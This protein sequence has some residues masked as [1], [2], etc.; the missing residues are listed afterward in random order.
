MHVTSTRPAP[1]KPSTPTP[2]RRGTARWVS[3]A[4][5][6]AA[7]STLLAAC[8][9]MSSTAP[10]SVAKA[11]PSVFFTNLKDGDSVTSPFIAKFGVRGM[12]VE[13]ALPTGEL[14]ANS[15]HHHVLVNLDSIK[16]G[17]AI[18]FT[19]QHNHFGKA[20]TEAEFKLAPGA[21]RLTLQFANAAH[22]SYGAGMSQTIRITVK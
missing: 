6:S 5:I 22:V 9:S 20:Q 10:A 16:S 18:P 2:R 14:K 7:L 12:A 15:G 21:Y 3:G 4:L 13:P 19:D 1:T 17:D 8:G 11:E